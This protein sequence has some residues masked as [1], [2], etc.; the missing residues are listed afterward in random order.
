MTTIWLDEEGPS[1]KVMALVVAQLTELGRAVQDKP[2][3]TA[4]CAE[5]ADKILAGVAEIGWKG[6]AFLGHAEL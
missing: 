2:E 1:G 6:W 5:P 4:V 3:L